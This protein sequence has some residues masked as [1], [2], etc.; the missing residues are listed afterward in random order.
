M[1]TQEQ[2]TNLQNKLSLLDNSSFFFCGFAHELSTDILTIAQLLQHSNDP[3]T[4]RLG[5]HLSLKANDIS[6]L[7]NQFAA[8]IN[9]ASGTHRRPYP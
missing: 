9:D 5:F 6:G 3:D 4:A 8:I 1:N 7:I 2:I